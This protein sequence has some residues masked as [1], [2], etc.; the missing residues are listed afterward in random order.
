M[1]LERVATLIRNDGGHAEVVA[2]DV[3]DDQSVADACERA[4]A[5]GPVDV[6]VNNAGVFDQTPFLLQDPQQRRREMEVNF[7][8]AQRMARALLPAMIRRSCGTIVNVSSIVGEIPCPSV[9]NY[10][11][12]K[13]A[14]NAWTHALRGEVGRHGIRLV[15]FIP[16]HTQTDRALETTRFDGVPALPVEDTVRELVRAID[17]APRS[18][19]ANPVF[20]MF[21]RLSK[22]FP[23][24]AEGQM[25]ATTRALLEPELP[26]SPRPALDVGAD[27]LS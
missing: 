20:R 16:N 23:R 18:V 22:I 4:L 3:T 25:A 10:S 5:G 13:A 19:A 8:G 9:S 6:L 11:A 21:L 27:R 17:R 7:F 2:L 15:V 26:A 14:L 1:E 24:W 12:T